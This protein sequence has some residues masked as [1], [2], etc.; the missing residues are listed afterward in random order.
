M[1]K[2]KVGDIVMLKDGIGKM[3]VVGVFPMNMIPSPDRIDV[4]DVNN[5]GFRGIGIPLA[6]VEYVC[7]DGE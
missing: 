2:V 5:P 7:E 3:K 4:T 1:I 6:W